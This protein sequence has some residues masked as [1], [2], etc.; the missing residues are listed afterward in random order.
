VHE[1]VLLT[2]HRSGEGSR[3][4]LA[5]AVQRVTGRPPVDVDARHFMTGGAGQLI[6]GPSGVRL[7]VPSTGLFVRPS[8]VIVYEIPPAARAGFRSFQRRLARS[9][10]RS[11]G[12]DVLAWR[13]AT[14]K[15]RSVA[16]FRRNGIAQMDTVVVR[17][18]DFTEV[19]SAFARL[20]GD[21][22][23]RPV[24]G[25]GGTDVFHITTD[26][27]LGEA[28]EHYAKLGSPWLMSRD[29]GNFN[30]A[31]VRHQF[32]VVVLGEEVVRVAEHVQ[33][34][35]DSPCNVVQGAVSTVHPIR[36]LAPGLLRLA[37]TATKSVGL[38]LGGVDLVAESGGAVF[39][40]NVHPVLDVQGG[41]ETIAIPYV[42]AH[43]A[44]T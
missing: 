17:R 31:G 29:A 13:D 7:E 26:N 10:V 44:L 22:W 30:D 6:S 33:S 19:R 8:V 2:D 23:A 35:P 27:Q 14:E 11:F 38:V 34:N 21:I 15:D 12:S 25:A 32:R 24:V 43:L 5:D 36:H 20:G 37:V 9:V 41:F 3:A 1:V 4:V 39:E 16:C 28:F 40:V 18:L 42:A